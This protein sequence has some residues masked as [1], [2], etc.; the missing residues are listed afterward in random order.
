[1]GATARRCLQL[2]TGAT[3]ALACV[4]VAPASAGTASFAVTGDCQEHQAFVDGDEA[5]VAARLPERYMPVRD[6][7]SGRPLLFARAVHCQRVTLG[8]RTAPATMASF[9]IVIDSPDGKGCASGAPALG[10][11][12]GDDPPICNWYTL[13]WLANDQRVVDWLRDGTPG[14]PA[15]Y[16]P[17]LIFDLG[18][19]DPAHD[20]APLH[21]EA[22]A[23]A[24]SPFTIDE[25]SRERPGEISV[26]GGYWADTPQGAVKLTASSDDLTSGDATGVVHAMPG[27][28]MAQ[29]FGADE[30]S[31]LPGYSSVAAERWQHLSYRKQ[32]LG[33]SDRADSFDGSCSLQGDVAFTPPATNTQT[34]LVYT[35]DASGTCTGTLDGRTVSDVP[36]KLHHSGPVDGSCLRARTT[37]PGQGAIAFADGTTIDYTLDFNF[38]LTEGD[39]ELYGARSGTAQG[40]GSFV[41]QR[42]PPDVASKC[43]G[44]G[45]AEAPMDMTLS[46][47]SPL[48]SERPAG[49]G[50]PGTP[51]PGRGPGARKR[52]RLAVSPQAVRVGHRIAFRFRVVTSDLTAA[53][54]ALVR[55]AGRRVHAGR[56][57]RATIVATLHRPG[58]WR[59]RATKRGFRA[60][61]VTVRARG[62]GA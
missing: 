18:A 30:R 48:V 37:A 26:R 33:P 61:Q 38:V 28:E 40:H 19:F 10:G 31:Y 59:A 41:T 16:V 4:G 42:T 62:A 15:V 21:V 5:A 39:F 52:L 29:L 12:K 54:G 34:P 45:L 25:I 2:A 20:G 55:F 36:V 51:G 24:P 58:R 50:E 11:V 17:G 57:G 3:A 32:V 35:Y 23:P 14:F 27:S 49:D 47:D 13:F 56:A 53:P 9:G 43:Y 8:G 46:T 6:P 44:E 22:P 7:S 1:M 60:A